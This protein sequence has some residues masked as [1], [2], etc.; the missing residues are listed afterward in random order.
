MLPD[1]ELQDKFLEVAE[2]Y[3]PE[4]HNILLAVNENC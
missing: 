4:K 1:E 2:D 3:K